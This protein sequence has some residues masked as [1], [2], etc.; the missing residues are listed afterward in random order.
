MQSSGASTFLYLLKQLLTLCGVGSV[1]RLQIHLAGSPR[2]LD[3][4]SDA[5]QGDRDTVVDLRTTSTP[6]ADF[7]PPLRHRRT[8]SK[9]LNEAV[10]VSLRRAVEIRR[11]R[12]GLRRRDPSQA[13]FLE[14][15]SSSLIG[16]RD[17]R[18]AVH[19][20]PPSAFL[21]STA[22]AAPG[23]IYNYYVPVQWFTKR[24]FGNLHT[25]AGVI[26][27]YFYST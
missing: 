24:G 3:K 12:G 8:T 15:I 19:V 16:H 6:S 7:D 26:G 2:T 11:A 25:G 5:T 27:G 21:S 4:C 9:Y 13:I 22:A 18:P 17:S 10:P 20:L 1:G 14:D 23:G